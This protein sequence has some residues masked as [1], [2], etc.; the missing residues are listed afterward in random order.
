MRCSSS[1]IRADSDSAVSS[2]STGT[3]ACRMIGPGVQLLIHEMHR[4]TADLHAVLERLLLGVESR[5]RGQ[6]RRMNVQN[7][8]GNAAQNSALSKRMKPARQTRSTPR[9][10]SSATTCRSY[11]SR[12]NAFGRN[13]QRRQPAL[14]SDLEAARLRPVRDHHRDLGLHRPAATLSAIASKFEPRPE[15]RMPSRF[16]GPHLRKPRADRAISPLRR[17]R[18]TARRSSRSMR[19][20]LREIALATPPESCRSPG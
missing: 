14:A 6:Q 18:R 2:S 11:S 15:S 13:A 9:L 5:K 4:A 10:F 20:R 16:T 12:A 17:S 19:P 3:A 7:P 1:R 8:Q